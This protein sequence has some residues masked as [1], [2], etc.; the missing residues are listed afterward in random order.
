MSNGQ[1][2]FI[3]DDEPVICATLL[4]ILSDAGHN[5]LAFEDGAMAMEA[6]A[7]KSPNLLISDVMMPRMNGVELAIH[8]QN[9]H[10]ECKVL[11]FSGA[12]V[13][14][15]LLVDARLRGY[16]FDLLTKPVHPSVLLQKLQAF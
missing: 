14:S 9:F 4:A 13:T 11:L 5:A 15:D 2:V 1:T 8:F 10:P 7:E 6:A 3:V 12:A 16:D